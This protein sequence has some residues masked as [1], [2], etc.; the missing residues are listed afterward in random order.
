MPMKRQKE[1][2]EDDA[3]DA[4]A[5]AMLNDP[6]LARQRLSVSKEGGLWCDAC[7]KDVSC[8]EIRYVLQ[9]CYGLQ[10]ANTREMF[11]ARPLEQRRKLAHFAS[12]ERLDQRDEEAKQLTAAIHQQRD[13]LQQRDAQ[14]RQAAAAVAEATTANRG[15]YSQLPAAT[16][17][18]RLSMLRFLYKHSIAPS[19]LVERFFSQLKIA[20]TPL[21]NSEHPDTL[22][23]RAMCMYNNPK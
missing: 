4:R 21:M 3:R 19:K 22:E 12:V 23:M 10:K 17:A 13:I 16:L 1:E 18:A 9:H 6:R 8:T 5:L 15:V 11:E 14:Q 2:G 7:G 20:T